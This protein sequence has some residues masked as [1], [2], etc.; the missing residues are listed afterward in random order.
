MG[1]N[2]ATI[3]GAHFRPVQ[4]SELYSF[5]SWVVEKSRPFPSQRACPLTVTVEPDVGYTILPWKVEGKV[6]EVTY[7]V[8]ILVRP[9]LRKLP[10]DTSVWGNVILKEV[11]DSLVLLG[12]IVRSVQSPIVLICSLADNIWSEDLEAVNVPL[13]GKHVINDGKLLDQR[14]LGEYWKGG[15]KGHIQPRLRRYGAQFCNR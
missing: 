6:L 10:P 15:L 12:R 2:G 11:V 1:V 5:S 13:A 14:Q 7:K 4:R 3:I 9:C 8:N